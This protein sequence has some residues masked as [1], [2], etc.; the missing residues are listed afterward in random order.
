MLKVKTCFHCKMFDVINGVA[1]LNREDGPRGTTLHEALSVSSQGA[2]EIS[3]AV[4]QPP[5]VVKDHFSSPRVVAKPCNRDERCGPSPQDHSI[6]IFT[7]TSNEGWGAHLEQVSKKIWGQT[8]KK[9]Y[10]QMS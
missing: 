2:L 8:G 9:G 3:S 5:S 4:G 6:Q 10:T 1:R 7:D